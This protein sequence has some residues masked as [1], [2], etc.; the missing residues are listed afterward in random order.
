MSR[1]GM[2]CMSH[3]SNTVYA[4]GRFSFLIVPGRVRVASLTRTAWAMIVRLPPLSHA[5]THL[6]HYLSDSKGT[7]TASWLD[8]TRDI[9]HMVNIVRPEPPLVGIGHSFGGAAIVNA[10]LFSPRLFTTVIL[11]D[12]VISPYSSTP[13]DIKDGPAAMSIR[14]RD[15]W[16][17]RQVA[18]QSFKKSPFYQSWDER[19]LK[20]WL[21]YGLAPANTNPAASDNQQ[22]QQQQQQNQGGPGDEAVTLATTKHQEVFTYLRPSW[23]AYDAGGKN[24]INRHLT[25]DLK[26]LYEG[27]NQEFNRTWPFYRPEPTS[28]LA[29]LPELRPST[30]YIFGGT[31]N[32]STAELRDEKLNTTGVGVGG[33]GGRTEG[34]VAGVVEEN[35]G[36]LVPLES[37]RF[38]AE[39][40]AGWLRP[41]LERWWKEENEY[42]KWAQTPQREKSTV[43]DEYIQ[44]LGAPSRIGNKEKS[45][46]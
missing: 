12:P 40:V 23:A 26:P 45:R 39:Q 41:E 10:A 4:S 35:A 46:L 11:L 44:N 37:P 9:V 8:Y 13:G 30:F 15:I 6:I 5:H 20:L 3:C 43:S 31:S 28:T 18:A 22:Q 42:E 29:K 1:C 27:P 17:S 34:R 14:R 7:A 24:L 19:V 21:E 16:P 33:S 32:L 36:H 25:P 2:T 38:C